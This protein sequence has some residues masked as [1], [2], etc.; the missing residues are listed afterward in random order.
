MAGDAIVVKV[1]LHVIWFRRSGKVTLMTIKAETRRIRVAGG[2]AR[3][4]GQRR[5]G[6]SEI[7]SCLGMVEIC[8]LPGRGRMAAGAVVVEVIRLM[9]RFGCRGIVRAVTVKTERR[10]VRVP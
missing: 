3:Y 4:T 2:V 1:V 8:R 10:G 7:E 9:V 5:V 6:S